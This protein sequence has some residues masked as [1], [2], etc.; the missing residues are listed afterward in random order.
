MRI[1][2]TA[3]LAV[4]F[5]A[6]PAYAQE[7]TGAGRVDVSVIP[8]GA[9]FFDDSSS[10]GEPAFGNYTVAAAVGWNFTRWIALES[11]IGTALG[12]KQELQFNSELFGNQRSPHFLAYN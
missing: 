3:V 4:T 5:A 2:C 7:R 6:W 10:D 9:M 11:E 12:V 1:L 8:A